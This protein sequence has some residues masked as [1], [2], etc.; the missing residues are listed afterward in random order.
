MALATYL[1]IGPRKTGSTYLQGTLWKNQ[2][3]LAENGILLPFGVR[4]AHSV[5]ARDFM[6]LPPRV[7]AEELQAWRWDTLTAELNAHPGRAVFSDEGL[8]AIRPDQVPSILS[9]IDGEVHVVAVARPL[10][11]LLVSAWQQSIKERSTHSLPTFLSKVATPGSQSDFWRAN[12]IS[13]VIATWEGQVPANR[14]HLVTMPGRGSDSALLWNRFARAAG[15]E[16]VPITPGGRRAN[17]SLDAAAIE[18]LRRFNLG[19]KKD[20]LP[21]PHPYRDV[22][23]IALTKRIRSFGRG[24]PVHFPTEWDA[25]LAEQTDRILSSLRSADITVHGVLEDIV[26]GE[27]PEATEAELDEADVVD[28]LAHALVRTIVEYEKAP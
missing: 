15:I 17:Q 26:P 3:V 10:D 8:A 12:D 20:E 13:R 28:V 25:W 1:H 16:E 19:L 22:V 7:S 23:R 5:A 4:R 2:E 9:S 11:A 18:A 14:L 6:G 21:F 24:A 27:R